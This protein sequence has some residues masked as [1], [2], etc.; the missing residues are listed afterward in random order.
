MLFRCSGFIA[1]ICLLLGTVARAD[2]YYVGLPGGG[3]GNRN[4]PA[5]WSDVQD[6]AGGAGTPGA[7]DSAFISNS[8]ALIRNI[9]ID[10]SPTIAGLWV[11]NSGGGVTTMY[12]PA[13]VSLTSTTE[14]IGYANSPRADYVQNG[15]T[16]TVN[17]LQIAG[18][19]SVG[20]DTQATYTMNGGTLLGD[21]TIAY[22]GDGTFQQNAG[23]VKGT[24][25]HLG[26]FRSSGGVYNLV[27]GSLSMQT[28]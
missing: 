2:R 13:G 9:N 19:S 24:S 11:G 1:V 21:I 3:T 7:A 5:N 4:N 20:D 27:S 8:D 6:G 16:N 17:D 28:E 23:T 10:V 15:G 22:D 18:Y 25:L 14:N 26:T 12:Q